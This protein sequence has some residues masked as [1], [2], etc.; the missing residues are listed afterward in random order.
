MSDYIENYRKNHKNPINRAL[1]SVGIP[2]IVISVIMFAV[3][4]LAYD[5][6]YW[7]WAV[8][9]FVVGWIL[10][11]IGHAFEGTY[12]SFFKNPFYLII[13]PVWWVLKIFGIKKK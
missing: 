8:G 1:H 10:Q 4:G 13:G 7:E 11:F 2:M 3:I 6:H 12:P 9:L 5:W